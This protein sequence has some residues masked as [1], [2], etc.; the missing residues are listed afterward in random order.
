M[1]YYMKESD[2]KETCW[3]RKG[4]LAVFMALTVLLLIPMPVNAEE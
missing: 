4:I 3:M 2:S 1:E